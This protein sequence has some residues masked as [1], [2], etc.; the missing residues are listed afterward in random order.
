MLHGLHP[1]GYHLVNIILH[2]TV[3]VLFTYVCQSVIF[4]QLLPSCIAGLLFAAHPIHTEAVSLLSLERFSPKVNEMHLL[5]RRNG[6]IVQSNFFIN[7][8]S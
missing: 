7:I 1:M 2:A 5:T 6:V 3:S 4:T 8:R